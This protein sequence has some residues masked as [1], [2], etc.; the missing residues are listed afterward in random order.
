MNITLK[1]PEPPPTDP[2]FEA[3]V[4]NCLARFDHDF[5]ARQP[6]HASLLELERLILRSFLYW[7]RKQDGTQT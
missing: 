5:T 7:L 3:A 4:E 2:T 6:D 1:L